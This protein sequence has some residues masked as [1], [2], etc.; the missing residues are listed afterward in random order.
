[1]LAWIDT[2]AHLDDARFDPDRDAVLARARAAGVEQV[3]TIGVDL[4]TSRAAVALA[5]KYPGVWAVV[6]V[7]PNHVAEAADG[8]FAEVEVLAQHLRV[9][10]IGETGLGRPRSRR[11]ES[12]LAFGEKPGPRP[13]NTRGERTGVRRGSGA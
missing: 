9:V 7:Q 2:H 6:G 11:P 5:E 8:D 12:R 4:A 10:A 1:M 13:A 3:L